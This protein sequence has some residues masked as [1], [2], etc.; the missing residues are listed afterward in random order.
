VRV[1]TKVSE[2][3]FEFSRG[4]HPR[5]ESFVIVGSLENGIYKEL[6]LVGERWI[7]T[8]RP[9]FQEFFESYQERCLDCALRLRLIASAKE[10]RRSKS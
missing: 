4:S 2:N 10:G 3:R 9:T 1:G 6:D 8:T 5:N 7:D